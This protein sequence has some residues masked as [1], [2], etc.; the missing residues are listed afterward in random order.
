MSLGLVK[1]VIRFPPPHE[2][3]QIPVWSGNAYFSRNSLEVI[4]RRFFRRR[5]S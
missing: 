2:L 3:M 4:P 1:P 5:T